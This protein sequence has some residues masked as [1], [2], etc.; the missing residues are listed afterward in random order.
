VLGLGQE[1]L[2]AHPEGIQTELLGIAIRDFLVLLLVHAE[3]FLVLVVL[4][5]IEPENPIELCLLSGF[6][7]AFDGLLACTEG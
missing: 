7:V 5:L 2:L 6:E 3:E 4:N 1:E